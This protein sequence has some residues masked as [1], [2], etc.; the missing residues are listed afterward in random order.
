MRH[1][2]TDVQSLSIALRFIRVENHLMNRP[3]SLTSSALPHVIYVTNTCNLYCLS[4][5]LD[6]QFLLYMHVYFSVTRNCLSTLTTCIDEMFHSVKFWRQ[7]DCLIER[8]LRRFQDY[9]SNIM[10]SVYIF[11]HFLNFIST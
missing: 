10:A 2:N 5:P 4:C 9:F 6:E 1:D 7:K 3:L 11:R 8:G